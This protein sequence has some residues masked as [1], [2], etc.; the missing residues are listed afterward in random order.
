MAYKAPDN[1]QR[2]AQDN[3]PQRDARPQPRV[4]GVHGRAL[5]R[6]L[7]KEPHDSVNGVKGDGGKQDAGSLARYAQHIPARAAARCVK[8]PKDHMLFCLFHDSPFFAFR[9]SGCPAK[10]RFHSV[11]VH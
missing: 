9:V 10:A 7:Q 8:D 1:R 4:R 6:S 2:N 11:N 5:Q 3:A